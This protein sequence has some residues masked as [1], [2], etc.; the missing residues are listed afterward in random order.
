M[1][2]LVAPRRRLHGVCGKSR[3][4]IFRHAPPHRLCPHLAYW[5]FV[6]IELLPR[7]TRIAGFSAW[8]TLVGCW[9]L[10]S[11]GETSP[12]QVGGAGM[13]VAVTDDGD[14]AALSATFSLRLRKVSDSLP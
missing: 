9:A 11:A 13:G 6:S 1:R 8:I 12:A 10:F 4:R 14:G 2:A 3:S 5:A 7:M